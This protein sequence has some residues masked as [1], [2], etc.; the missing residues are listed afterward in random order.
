VKFL[1]DQNRPPQLAASLR[2]AGHDAVHT[3]DLG[4]ERAPDAV[5]F[6]LAAQQGRVVISGDS[7]FAAILAER[8]STTPSVVLFR[9]RGRRRASE[10]AAL[11]LANLDAIAEDLLA[12]AIAKSI[13]FE[14]NH[15]A[16]T[17][18]E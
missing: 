7:D 5:I 4:L 9:L 14:C 15:H 16:S 2:E 10:Q 3:I 6:E 13:L 12:G 1:V 8:G 17:P 11:L 18:S